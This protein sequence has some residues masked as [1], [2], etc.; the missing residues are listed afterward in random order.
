MSKV[1]NQNQEAA[2]KADTK[3]ATNQRN[4]AFVR[5]IAN[6]GLTQLRKELDKDAVRANQSSGSLNDY[7]RTVG[8]SLVEQFKQDVEGMIRD[9][10]VL[11]QHHGEVMTVAGETRPVKRWVLAFLA[12][13]PTDGQ[14]LKSYKKMGDELAS[15]IK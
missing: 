12:A 3:T 14:I 4:K 15:T 9:I 1:Q 7:L 13:N 2:P 5:L 8:E 6:K 11:D 10:A